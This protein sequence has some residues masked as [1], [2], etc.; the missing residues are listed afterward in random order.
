MEHES[1]ISACRAKAHRKSFYNAYN[2]TFEVVRAEN[3]WWKE[4]AWNLR[5]QVFC[6]ENKWLES[7]DP[8][9]EI[10]RDQYDVHADQ[11]L[12]VHRETNKIAG[13]LR[14]VMPETGRPL[15]S[16]QTQEL[17]NHP[18]VQDAANAV[19]FCEISR[20]CMAASYRRRDRDG[21]ILP[22]YYEQEQVSSG[23]F[24]LFRRYIPYAPLG[25]IA[26]AFE[27]VLAA[28]KKDC[29]MMLEPDTLMT[30]ARIGIPVERL[31]DPVQDGPFSWQPVALN[32][33]TVFEHI[34]EINPLCWEVLSDRGRLHKW[35]GKTM[36]QSFDLPVLTTGFSENPQPGAHS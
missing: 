20:L 26:A 16:F 29:L 31:G 8:L 2:K 9:K 35:A 33:P 36:N 18:L 27:A 4:Q 6:K 23:G 1:F 14:V 19:R 11:F 24:S 10:E 3:K 32:I 30:F 25:L 15:T 17:C 22:A 34:A 13:T 28:G 7:S 5:Y 21:A 12:L